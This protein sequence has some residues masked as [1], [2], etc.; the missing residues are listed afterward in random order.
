[1]DALSSAVRIWGLNHNGMP[2]DF[3]EFAANP[4]GTVIPPPP[5]GKKYA[6]DHK[7]HVI[8]VNR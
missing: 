5:P 2:K 4:D 8:L 6:F 1:L 7:K 3:Q